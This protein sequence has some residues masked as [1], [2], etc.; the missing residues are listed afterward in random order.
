MKWEAA[1]EGLDEDAEQVE[2]SSKRP[3]KK[4]RTYNDSE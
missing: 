2:E 1:V 4:R 3:Q